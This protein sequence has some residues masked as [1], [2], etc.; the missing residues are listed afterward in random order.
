MAVI[1]VGG[2]CL[3][4]IIMSTLLLWTLGVLIRLST[5]KIVCYSCL[6]SI[7]VYYY[8]DIILNREILFGYLLF[9]LFQ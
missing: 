2:G 6:W 7:T 9:N 5:P 1:G 4:E 8:N 3:C